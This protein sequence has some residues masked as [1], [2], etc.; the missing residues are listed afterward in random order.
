MCCS[1]GRRSTAPTTRMPSVARAARVHHGQAGT[2]TTSAAGWNSRARHAC[3]RLRSTPKGRTAPPHHQRMASAI[4]AGNSARSGCATTGECRRSRCRSRRSTPS[5]PPPP[6]A[7]TRASRG[8][9]LPAAATRSPRRQSCLRH[10]GAPSCW[11]GLVILS[12]SASSPGTAA[13]YPHRPLTPNSALSAE[14]ST[15]ATVAAHA[16][17]RFRHSLSHGLA[18]SRSPRRCSGSS[19]RY[20]VR[21]GDVEPDGARLAPVVIDVALFSVFALHHSV[22]ARSSVKATLTALL[23]QDSSVQHYT[24]VASLLFIAVCTWWQP[25]PGL[26]YDLDGAARVLRVVATGARH[27]ADSARLECARY[28]RPR[29]RAPARSAPRF[30]RA[31]AAANADHPRALRVRASPAVFCLGALRVRDARHDRTRAAFAIISTAY[32]MLAI[33]WEERGLVATFG[34]EYEAYRQRVRTRMIPF[35]Y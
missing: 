30:G 5:G 24:W 4:A 29:G 13:A 8:R 23:P 11:H 22:L 33:P 25:V 31:E 1:C 6:P 18:R 32:L 34:P 19:I 28:P 16:P 21:F 17:G 27:R 9:S 3:H 20:L 14:S 10:F 35:V 7:S 26:L 2:S 12:L 15:L